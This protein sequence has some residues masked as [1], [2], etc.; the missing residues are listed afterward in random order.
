MIRVIRD[1]LYADREMLPNFGF[2]MEDLIGRAPRRKISCALSK[3]LKFSKG[4]RCGPGMR[5]AHRARARDPSRVEKTGF[6]PLFGRFWPFSDQN[7]AMSAHV[8]ICFGILEHL[9]YFG[10][11][12]QKCGAHTAWL[13]VWI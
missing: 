8:G 7:A 13:K 11:S 2:P 3:G 12:R 1:R 5:C 6:E 4:P 9:N 10:G